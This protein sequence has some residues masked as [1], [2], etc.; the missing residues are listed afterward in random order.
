MIEAQKRATLAFLPW[1]AAL[2][3]FLFSFA[4]AHLAQAANETN[5]GPAK[6]TIPELLANKEKWQSRRVE[7]MGYYA[8]MAEVSAVYSTADEAKQ[9]D[10]YS[11]QGI[12]INFDGSP[13]I[14]PLKQGPLRVV[15]T[16]KYYTH[17]GAGHLAQW[18]AE[19]REIQF[20][21]NIPA[22]KSH[23]GTNSPAKTIFR[24]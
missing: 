10:L 23:A 12:W 22:P 6:V 17:R 9:P 13:K 21:Q 14:F 8:Q 7:V 2:M 19:I 15:G 16:F 24:H 11:K 1:S 18:P 4:A 5:A 3:L 20:M